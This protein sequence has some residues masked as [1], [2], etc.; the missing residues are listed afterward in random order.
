MDFADIL[1]NRFDGGAEMK[2][3]NSALICFSN[4]ET[5]KILSRLATHITRSKSEKSAITLLYFIDKERELRHSDE[6]EEYQNKI[7]SNF[8]PTEERDKITLRLFIKASEDYLADIIRVCEE[9]NCNLLISGMKNNEF[10]PGLIKKYSQLKN[11]PANSET[12]IFEQF[13]E[14]DAKALKIINALFNR[15]TSSVGLFI[16]NGAS[17][18]RKLFIPIL[19]KS[20]IHI[21]TY[22]YRIAQK[23][24]VK[25][26]VWDAIGIIHSDPKMQKLYQFIVKKTEAGLYLWN[27][28]KKIGCD[29]IREQDLIIIGAE[30]WNKLICTPLPWIDCLPSTLIIKEKTNSM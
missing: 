27:N 28:D 29:F 11:D 18:F 16:D 19:H 20:D 10:G 21:F 6:M 17:E 26:M 9:Q 2:K 1:L 13:G 24:N 5:G 30:G 23:E 25:I 15:T 4:L 12:F 14:R 22:L 7:I 3:P 8:I